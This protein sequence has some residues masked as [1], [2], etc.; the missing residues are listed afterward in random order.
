MTSNALP[1]I[2]VIKLG[3]LGDFTQ[4]FGPFQAIRKHHPDARISLLTTRPFAGLAAASLWFDEIL[5]DR[6]PGRLDLCGWLALRKTLR[7]G[8]FSR[9][10]DLQTSA[11]SSRYRR[12]FFPDPSPEWSGIA[13]G[14]S[15]P[16]RNPDRDDMH[17]VDRQA[18]QLRD[19]GIPE[20][21]PPDTDWI[22]GDPGRFDLPDRFALIVP[23]G[24]AHRPEKRWPAG[25]YQTVIAALAERGLTS[26]LI[27]SPDE[28]ALHDHIITSQPTAVS[29]AGRTEFQD[30]VALG[31]TAAL[32]IGNDTGPMHLIA[33]SACPTIVL[34]S[35]ASDPALCAPRG[36]AVTLLQSPSLSDLSPD[37]VIAA[38]PAL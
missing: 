7:A 36:E 38:L 5:T 28:A 33:L 32:A 25:H 4:A 29:L 9:V 22:T 16:H 26:V 23:G 27:G 11:R 31:R 12:L 21:P 37:R 8:R 19:A 30:I 3:A 24:S 14:C 13:P 1:R 15:H 18:E 17:T 35:G 6:R 2:L 34:F 20:T 10:Y